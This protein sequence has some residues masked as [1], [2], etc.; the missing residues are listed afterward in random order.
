MKSL[1]YSY[2]TF[3]YAFLYT[4]IIVVVFFSFNNSNVSLLWHG[5]TWHWYRVLFH[6]A[7][8]GAVALHSF[9]LGIIAA[10]VATGM[11]LIASVAL[12]RYRFFGKQAFQLLI[13]VMIVLPDLVIGVALLILMSTVHFPLGFW[14]LLVAH[15]TFCLPFTTV[16]IGN[17]LRQLNKHTLEAGRDLGASQWQLYRDVIIPLVMP[18]LVASWLLSFTMSI[19]DVIISYFVSGPSYEILPLRIYSMVKMGVSPEVNALCSLLLVIT[20]A[21][22]LLAQRRIVK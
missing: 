9:W 21:M 11:G 17:Q 18:G 8:L 1:R 12:F 19:D 4:P 15:I 22:T 10:T 5:F 16:I 6:D 20:F 2:L 3:I 13:F 7:D 14:S